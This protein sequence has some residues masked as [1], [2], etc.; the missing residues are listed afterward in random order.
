MLISVLENVR[1]GRVRDNNDDDD[2]NNDRYRPT[3]PRYTYLSL[4]LF[5]DGFRRSAAT[6]FVLGLFRVSFWRGRAF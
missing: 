4:R 3:T 5:S 6:S 1:A 2:N